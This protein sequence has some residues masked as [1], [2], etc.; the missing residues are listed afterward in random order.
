M[1]AIPI[2]S[3]PLL[4]SLEEGVWRAFVAGDADADAALLDDDFVGVYASGFSNRDQHVAPLRAGPAAVR[5]QLDQARLV[6]TAPGAGLLSYRAQWLRPN[7]EQ[8]ETM[9]I[10]SLWLH[11]D[12]QWRN[13]FSQDTPV[14]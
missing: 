3:L 12:G 7:A 13:L 11:R 5:Y 1:N 9:Y 8:E 6:W 2:P 14:P 10:S 4:L